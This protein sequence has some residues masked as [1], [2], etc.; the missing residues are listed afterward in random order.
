MKK[1]LKKIKKRNI[2]VCS[3]GDSKDEVKK[4]DISRNRYGNTAADYTE[5]CTCNYICRV[6]HEKIHSGESHESSKDEYR[7]KQLL[8]HE[9]HHDRNCK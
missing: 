8:T 6:M 9:E 2:P 4:W 1:T 5:Q 3:V 7:D